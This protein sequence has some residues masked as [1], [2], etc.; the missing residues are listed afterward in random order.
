[1]PVECLLDANIF[2]Y[3]VDSTPANSSK[4]AAA[5]KLIEKSDFGLSAQIM[6]E[7]YVT[8]TRKFQKPLSPDKAI[9]FLEQ[10]NAFP[11]IPTDYDLITE[12]IR[13]S[14]KYKISYWDGA[15]LAAAERLK[16]RILYSEDLNHGQIY[17]TVKVINPF[18]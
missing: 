13:N 5:L 18:L 14:V 17:E 2:V 15:V 9:L 12:G 1:M 6:Q 4:K 10:F 16:A 7:F 11:V 8:V 3:A